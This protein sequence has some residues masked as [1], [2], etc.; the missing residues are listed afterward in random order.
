M[1]AP[2][3]MTASALLD[4]LGAPLSPR[5]VDVCV[6]ED[7]SADPYLIPGS[8]RHPHTDM[9]GLVEKL[10]GHSVVVVCQKGLKLS[11]GV[12]A[13][14][15]AEGVDARYLQ[16]GMFAWKVLPHAPR[17]PVSALPTPMDGRTTWVTHD[18]QDMDRLAV[19]WLLTRFLDRD[20]R[21]LFV[22]ATQVSNVADRFGATPVTGSFEDW[23][24]RFDP[25]LSGLQAFA[26][27]LAASDLAGICSGFKQ[28]H[29]NGLEH[30]TAV[31]PVFDAIYA[32]AKAESHEVAA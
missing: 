3:S 15:R 18:A 24:A 10:Q 12:A 19:L 21:I 31:Q 23:I 26:S 11:Q 2:N 7:F 20:A 25:A 16:G 8:V 30:L 22:E 28:L 17:I 29:G 1:P 4:K 27:M 5:I 32:E 14:L 6:D 9:A 13:W